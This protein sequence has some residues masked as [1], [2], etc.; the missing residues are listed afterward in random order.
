M[1]DKL[2]EWRNKVNRKKHKVK[3]R[4]RMRK[5]WEKLELRPESKLK[6]LKELKWKVED[7][8]MEDWCQHNQRKNFEAKK[9]V[10]R[11]QQSW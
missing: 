8:P 4:N 9:E 5:N 7:I 3:L 1:M 6:E 10:R 2:K 11:V